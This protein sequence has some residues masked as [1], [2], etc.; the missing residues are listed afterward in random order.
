[1]S[2]NALNFNDFGG[3]M[4]EKSIK[5]RS[6][7]RFTNVNFRSNYDRIFRKNECKCEN[8]GQKCEKG[9]KCSCKQSEED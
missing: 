9:D 4:S 6:L 2:G 7:Q 5:S 3:K 1:M 8:N